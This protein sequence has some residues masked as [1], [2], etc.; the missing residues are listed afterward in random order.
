MH[1]FGQRLRLHAFVYLDGSLSGVEDYET[2]RALSDVS[3]DALPKLHVYDV[4]QIII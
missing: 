3:F 1:L 4:I 2:I